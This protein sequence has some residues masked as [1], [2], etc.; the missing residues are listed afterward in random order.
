L[1]SD[2]WI[3]VELLY[4]DI[5]GIVSNVSCTVSYCIVRYPVIATP[6]PYTHFFAFPLGHQ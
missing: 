3:I 5:I 6:T 2:I 1:S 4:R